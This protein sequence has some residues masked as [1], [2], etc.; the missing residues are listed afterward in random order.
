MLPDDATAALVINGLKRPYTPHALTQMLSESGVVK[1]ESVSESMIGAQPLLGCCGRACIYMSVAVL[2]VCRSRLGGS[3]GQGC[4]GVLC[5][6]LGWWQPGYI[7]AIELLM[8]NV[9]AEHVFAHGDSHLVSAVLLSR[10]TGMFLTRFKD[11]A[12]V[13]FQEASHAHATRHKLQVCL[14]APGLCSA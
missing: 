9:G 1:G 10:C 2:G 11:T 13:V 4:C 7:T 12:Y 6:G 8:L 3:A 14:D 5:S